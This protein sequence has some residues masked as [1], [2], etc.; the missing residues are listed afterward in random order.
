MIT[1]ICPKCNLPKEFP[2]EFNSEGKYCRIC[3]N[4]KNREWREKNPE[5][6]KES[7]KKE[8]A[9]RKPL[10]KGINT[11]MIDHSIFKSSEI[12]YQRRTR[13]RNTLWIL[14]Y[15]KTHPCVDCGTT[16][17]VLLE[18]DHVRGKKSFN[19]G[20]MTGRAGASLAKIQEEV[21]KC[22]VRCANCHTKKTAKERGYISYKI[23]HEDFLNSTEGIALQSEPIK[24]NVNKSDRLRDKKGKILKY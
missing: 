3:H 14:D 18:F 11:T 10:R 20:Q 16:D 19:I 15:F 8:C 22:D 6:Y 2:N 1:K 12:F 23:L 24:K 21:K 4:Q 17:A 13:L 5:R 7:Q 9:R